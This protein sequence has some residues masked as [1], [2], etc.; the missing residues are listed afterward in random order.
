[1]HTP[2]QMADQAHDD[3]RQVRQRQQVRR[4]AFIL[5]S[6][7]AA[8]FIGVIARRWWLGG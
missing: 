3:L 8:F 1:M 7:A 6:I 5:A 2:S 4:T